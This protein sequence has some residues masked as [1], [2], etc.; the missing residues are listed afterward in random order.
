[1]RVVWQAGSLVGL[2]LLCIQVKLGLEK[3]QLVKEAQTMLYAW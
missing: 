1:M 2:S 3:I